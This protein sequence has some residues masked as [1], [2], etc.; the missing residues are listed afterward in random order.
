MK[1]RPTFTEFKKKALQDKEVRIEYERLGP[2]FEIKKEHIKARLQKGLTQE[3]VAKMIGTSK[4]NIS[5]L[6]SPN[7]SVM[8]NIATILKYADAL[9]CNIEFKLTAR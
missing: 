9:G 1:S 3:D 6:E 7:S 5:R 2:L 4:S 8:P